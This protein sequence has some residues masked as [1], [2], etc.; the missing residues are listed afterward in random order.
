MVKDAAKMASGLTS[1][2][3]EAVSVF[4]AKAADT[5][6]GMFY[7][8]PIVLPAE[9]RVLQRL[10]KPTIQRRQAAK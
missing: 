9:M 6:V 4:T 3:V 10:Q 8:L 7:A 1:A 5:I 2:A